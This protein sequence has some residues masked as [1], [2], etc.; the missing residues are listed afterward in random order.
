MESK[1]WPRRTRLPPLPEH[2]TLPHTGPQD[3]G[4]RS[5]PL[6]GDVSVLAAEL[7][8]FLSGAFQG[9][10]RDW[11]LE[12]LDI[13]RLLRPFRERLASACGLLLPS[14]ERLNRQYER[15]RLRLSD[16]DV[17]GALHAALPSDS[18]TLFRLPG[19]L[20]N[21]PRAQQ[22]PLYLHELAHYVGDVGAELAAGES[23]WQCGPKGVPQ[24][25]RTDLPMKVCSYTAPVASKVPDVLQQNLEPEKCAGATS[26]QV[27]GYE[28]AEIL[29]KSRHLGKVIFMYLNKTCGIRD[30][31]YDL[32]GTH[33]SQLHPEHFVF[34]PF[35]ILHVNPVNGSEVQELGVW[36]REAV[37]CR[38]L[39]KIP[40]Y[41]DFLKRRTFRWWRRYVRRICFLR[42]RSML[43]R[44]L[45]MSVPH[46]TAALHHINRFLQ[47]LTQ[48]LRLPPHVSTPRSIHQLET[49]QIHMRSQVKSHL[50]SLL[51]L[52]SHILEMV[53]YERG[54]QRKVP[55]LKL[56]SSKAMMEVMRRGTRN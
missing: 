48:L 1:Q 32:R 3:S 9:F 17:P 56:R 21:L 49:A 20:E 14:L 34:S 35:G 27:T 45:L 52:V 11:W 30:C 37:L 25:L 55:G 47:E 54:S 38:T 22:P 10:D 4:S 31:F 43:K 51:S 5:S 24:A 19:D 29:V 28:A 8:Q 33:V 36:H 41:R 7:L 15:H 50:C 40:F 39:R 46:Y 13:L 23:M 2:V 44:R 26:H 16:L 12:L 6:A 42:R 18:S 53:R